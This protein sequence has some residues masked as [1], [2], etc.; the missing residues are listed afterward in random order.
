MTNSIDFIYSNFWAGRLSGFILAF[1]SISLAIQAEV[2]NPDAERFAGTFAQFARSDQNAF[3]VTND[4]TLF[5]GSSSI[6]L[7]KSLKD[8]FPEINLA[9][10]GFGGAHISD[11]IHFYDRLFPL[12]KPNRIVMYCGENDLWSGK[13]VDQ[14]FSDFTT[15]WNRIQKDLPQTTFLYLSCKPS[16]SRISK[17]SLYESL[18]LKIKNSAVKDDKITYVNISPA[19]LKPDLTFYPGLW[20]KDNLHMNQ[21]GYDKW[22]NLLRPILGLK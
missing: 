20:Q 8:D 4:L 2:K 7:W 16:P 13:P 19:L 11:V 1:V 22:T 21:L 6:R 12:Y 9:N 3:P 14:V 17:W 5:T 18:N 10:R 15:L